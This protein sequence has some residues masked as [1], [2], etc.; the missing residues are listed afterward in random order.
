MIK[1]SIPVLNF[2]SLFIELA[3]KWHPKIE[4]DLNTHLNC[5]TLKMT[6]KMA[7]LKSV[8]VQLLMIVFQTGEAA[9]FK[10]MTLPSSSL[11]GSV[12]QEATASGK[13]ECASLCQA[14]VESCQI[15]LFN[16]ITGHCQLVNTNEPSQS[17]E[18][19]SNNVVAYYD[20]GE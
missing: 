9:L 1:N 6:L 18:L 13:I 11:P 15:Y 2:G 5:P 14:A 8:I 7:N 19:I 17:S 16:E 4:S 12:L 10:K 3:D 20:Y